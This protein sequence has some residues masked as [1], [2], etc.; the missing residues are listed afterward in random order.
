M[1]GDDHGRPPHELVD[2]K[3]IVAGE[4]TGGRVGELEETY[5]AIFVGSVA[6]VVEE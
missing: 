1:F 5:P 3:D 4:V 6:G 2:L